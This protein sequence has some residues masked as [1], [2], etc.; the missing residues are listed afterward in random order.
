MLCISQNAPK[1]TNRESI[2]SSSTLEWIDKVFIVND[3]RTDMD[4]KV[5]NVR[6]LSKDKTREKKWSGFGKTLLCVDFLN[7]VKVRES[8]T[9]CISREM[10]A[11]GYGGGF[12][13]QQLQTPVKGESQ[14]YGSQSDSQAPFGSPMAK[15]PLSSLSVCL[16]RSLMLN[17][18]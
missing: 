6:K 4:Q 15:M 12:L 16:S 8:W 5:Y 3:G 11:G 2:C 17:L 7:K 18:K 14:G 9:R 10:G 1:K 13:Q